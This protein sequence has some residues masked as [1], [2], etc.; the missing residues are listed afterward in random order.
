MIDD[1]TLIIFGATGNLAQVKLFPALYRLEAAGALP[2]RLRI[3]C[4]GRTKY[5]QH[6][7]QTHVAAAIDRH[8]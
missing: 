2:P 4:N 5:D 3:L 8:G 7:W 1:A 6:A